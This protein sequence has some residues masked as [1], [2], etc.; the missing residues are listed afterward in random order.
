MRLFIVLLKLKIDSTYFKSKFIEL[1]IHGKIIYKNK[2][3]L[4]K[5]DYTESEQ[6]RDI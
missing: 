5:E 2:K 4:S 3:L 6:K 1:G